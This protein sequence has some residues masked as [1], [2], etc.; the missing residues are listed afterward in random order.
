VAPNL[1]YKRGRVLTS[2][3]RSEIP[4]STIGLFMVSF[5]RLAMRLERRLM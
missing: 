4:K 2:H 1:R 3:S 5:D